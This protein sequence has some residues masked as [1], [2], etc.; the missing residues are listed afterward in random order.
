[1]M[2]NII[3]YDSDHPGAVKN[4]C[5]EQNGL[6]QGWADTFTLGLAE[7]AKARGWEIVTAD[8][9]L[10]GKYSQGMVVFCITDMWSKKT[11]SILAKGAIPFMCFSVESPLI[12]KDFYFNIKRLAGRYIYNRQFKGT[13]ERLIK[14]PTRFSTMYFPVDSR[15]PLPHADWKNRKYLVLI[16]SNKRIFYSDVTSLKGL[17]KSMLSRLKLSILKL[18]DPWIRSKEIYKDRIEAIY[19]FSRYDDFV[20]HG[21]GWDNKIPGF[22]DKYHAS[23]KKAYRGSLPF[24]EKLKTLNQ[25]KFVICFENCSFPGYVTEKIFDCFLAGSIPV[26]YGAPDITDFV[27]RNSFIDFRAFNSYE[28]L[29]CYLRNM[30]EADA[31]AML[32][33]AAKF[34]AGKDFDRHHIKNVVQDIMDSIDQYPAILDTKQGIVP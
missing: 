21:R 20:L 13:E 5:F 25:F 10:E 4:R 18:V 11:K 9:F 6:L 8:V 19:Y 7:G 3:V 27:P 33:V 28:E 16:N 2:K 15:T 23:A 17:V 31:N 1:M 26:Y 29:D 34:L 32:E 12:A 30:P 14:T 24:G 22:P